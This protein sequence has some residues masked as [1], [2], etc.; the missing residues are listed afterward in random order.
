MI[1]ESPC[2]SPV[3]RTNAGHPLRYCK[4]REGGDGTR[5]PGIAS[6]ALFPTCSASAKLKALCDRLG[7]RYMPEFRVLHSSKCLVLRKCLL[8][9]AASIALIDILSVLSPSLKDLFQFFSR[10]RPQN[11]RITDL[12][13]LNPLRATLGADQFQVKM[14]GGCPRSEKKPAISFNSKPVQ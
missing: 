10:N 13:P 2:I 9:N 1:Y 4:T 14:L 7:N 8:I 3:D 12:L 6:Q 5:V 11:P